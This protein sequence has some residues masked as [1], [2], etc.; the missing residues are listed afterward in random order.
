MT[1]RLFSAGGGESSRVRSDKLTLTFADGWGRSGAAQTDRVED[2]PR[3]GPGSGEPEQEIG[4]RVVRS[5]G[6]EY[7]H[8]G[9]EAALSGDRRQADPDA[10]PR[11]AAA[12]AL[13][14]RRG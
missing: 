6:R 5:G 12:V 8:A 1:R 10:A 4:R 14:A 9:Q 13:P 2:R 7:Q 11:P 3:A